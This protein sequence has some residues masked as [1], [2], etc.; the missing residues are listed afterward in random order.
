[1]AAPRIVAI[2]D[3]NADVILRS[4]LPARGTQVLVERMEIHGGGCATNFA[5]AC[6]RFGA[7]VKL[8]ARVGRDIIGEMILEKL[9]REGVDISGV[10]FG[11]RGTGITVALVEGRDRSFISFRGEN[12]VFCEE[13]IGEVEGDLVHFP[14]FFLLR[15]LQP[16]YPSLMG[17]V[18]KSGA[19]VSFDTG[20]DP[21]GRWARNRF[22]M[23]AI[24]EADIFFPNL[25]EAREILRKKW[26]AQRLARELI[27]LGP[28]MV[29]IKMGEK[30]ALAAEA[31]G[32]IYS[33]NAPKVKVIDTTGAGDVFNAGFVVS[34]LRTKD[35]RFSLRFGC[36]AAALS[37]TG[38]GWEKYPG[39]RDVERLCCRLG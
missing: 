8:V 21:A 27:A 37:I 1:M 10:S 7:K 5:F 33:S 30:G 23:P 16:S 18:K 29:A 35:L 3:I 14:S 15:A 11:E 24:R 9:R 6:A 25:R 2:G 22:L 19:M 36:A 20:W 4:R 31:G 32:E 38:I 28:R 34:Y 12:E 17:R 13:E 39:F 26:G